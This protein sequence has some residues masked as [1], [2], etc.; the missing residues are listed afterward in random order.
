MKK[1]VTLR[2]ALTDPRL[3]AEALPGESWFGWRSLLLAI[4]GEPLEQAELE[5]FKKL[6]AREVPPEKMVEEFLAIIGRRGGKSRA[7]SVLACYVSALC[8]FSDRLVKGERPVLLLLAPDQRQSR[9]LLS[10]ISGVF[11][12]SPVLSKMVIDTTV[13]TMSLSNGVDIEVRAASFRRVRGLTTIGILA[14]EISF[15]YDQDTSANSDAEIIN[16]VRPS[17]ATTGGPLFMITTPYSK[18]GLAW[19]TYKQHFGPQG[20]PLIVVAQGASRDLNPSLPEK[21]VLRA[22]ERDEA[23]AKAEF[24]GEF[25]ADLENFISREQVERITIPGRVEIPP[26]AGV[27]YYGF[28]DPSGGAKD[29]FTLAIAHCEKEKI[30]LDCIREKRPPFSPAD[31]VTEFAAILKTYRLAKV[32][33]DRYAGEWPRERF[34]ESGIEYV[35]S[36]LTKSEIYGE[37]LPLV[38]ALKIELLDNKRLTNQI[39]GLERRTGRGTGREVIDHSVNGMDD[40]SNAVAGALVEASKR[41]A[42]KLVGPAGGTKSSNENFGPLGDGGYGTNDGYMGN[43]DYSEY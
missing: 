9:I 22:L 5:V 7:I 25:R 31:V 8:D 28:T 33:G 17:L 14:D 3:L 42:R 32:K 16:A 15:W 20:D 34:Q 21:V 27:T 13:D 10:Y 1:T 6:T 24:L 23:A 36:D 18:K 11:E 35:T 38:N 29:S 43:A 39:T 37:F 41:K 4:M 2:Q 40:I 12:Q 19:E 26:I 30:I